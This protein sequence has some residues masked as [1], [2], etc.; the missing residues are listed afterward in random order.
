[1]KFR[2]KALHMGAWSK[3][4]NSWAQ[5]GLVLV[6]KE[7]LIPLTTNGGGLIWIL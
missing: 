5:L 3:I 1:M 7:K 2:I 4:N 6:L